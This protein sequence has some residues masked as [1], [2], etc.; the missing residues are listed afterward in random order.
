[1]ALV[2]ATT[3]LSGAILVSAV[4]PAVPDSE[5]S[6]PAALTAAPAYGFSGRE[7]STFRWDYPYVF[8][9]HEV[10]P[11]VNRTVNTEPLTNAT[12][13]ILE[14]HW[15]SSTPHVGDGLLVFEVFINGER[16]NAT[17][18]RDE[19]GVQRLELHEEDLQGGVLYTNVGAPRNLTSPNVRP[20]DWLAIHITKFS[21]TPDWAFSAVPGGRGADEGAYQKP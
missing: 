3:A 6:P 13:I 8:L 15:A 19:R 12:G 4:M 20:V 5:A 14:L 16:L 9:G 1:M 7:T 11:A 17:T 2:V 18:H 21:G 10:R